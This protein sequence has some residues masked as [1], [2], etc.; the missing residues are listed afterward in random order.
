MKRE[1]E[2]RKEATVCDYTWRLGWRLG[3][4]YSQ[5]MG[6]NRSSGLLSEPGQGEA[7]WTHEPRDEL[8]EKEMRST[9]SKGRDTWDESGSDRAGH[10]RTLRSEELVLSG[11]Y[12][13]SE[14]R[15]LTVSLV[16]QNTVSPP[17]KFISSLS[18]SHGEI[19]GNKGKYSD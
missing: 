6:K 9:R 19:K 12:F 17:A 4:G 14:T 7:A 10:S 15:F 13:F 11:L 3:L 5:E 1:R 18:S 8:S 16:L 2:P